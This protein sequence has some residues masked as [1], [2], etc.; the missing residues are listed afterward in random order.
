MTDPV[1]AWHQE[2]ESFNKLLSILRKEIDV[3][4]SEGEP[5]YR[6]MLDIISYLRDFADTFHHPREDEAFRLLAQRCPDRELPLA[7][8]RQ[9]HVVIAHAGEELRA[10]LEQA[11]NDEV[12]LRSRVEVAA[13]TYLVYYSNHIRVEEED[14]LPLARRTLTDAEWLSVKA[15]VP[16]RKASSNDTSTDS[17]LRDLYT[18]IVAAAK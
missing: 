1:A 11:A 14:V 13:A 8:L 17:Y 6:L 5:D 12:T 2:H 16:P 10:L 4:H 9:E 3:F 15:V 7:R 18:R